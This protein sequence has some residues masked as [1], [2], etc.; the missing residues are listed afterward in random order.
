M[1]ERDEKQLQR[2][3]IEGE[4]PIDVGLYHNDHVNNSTMN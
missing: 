4:Q 2:I 3:Y 1:A